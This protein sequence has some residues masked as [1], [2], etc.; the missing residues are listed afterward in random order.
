M[1]SR[2]S[3]QGQKS[4]C[5]KGNGFTTG[6][7]SGDNKEV[8]VFSKTDVNGNG[9]FP[10]NERVACLFQ[11]NAFLCIENGFCGIHIQCKSCSGKNEIQLDHNV[12]VCANGVHILGG[13]FT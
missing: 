7:W 11:M 9:F 3:H 1:K 12:K 2:L 6:V 8:E 13:L 5:L 10:G 4:N